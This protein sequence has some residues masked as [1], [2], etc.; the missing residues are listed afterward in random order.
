MKH[1][2]STIDTWIKCPRVAGTSRVNPPVAFRDLRAVRPLRRSSASLYTAT[3]HSDEAGIQ[4]KVRTFPLS[5]GNDYVD[6][7]SRTPPKYC[8]TKSAAQ[9][10][11]ESGATQWSCMTFRSSLPYSFSIVRLTCQDSICI[12]SHYT[13]PMIPVGCSKMCATRVIDFSPDGTWGAR[14][15]NFW[16]PES[17]GKKFP[18]FGPLSLKF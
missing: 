17:D 11:E 14:P 15:Y 1:C 2:T 8:F 16:K 13:G 18:L 5:H 9:V 7:P 12:G 3:N 4:D 6:S 10:A